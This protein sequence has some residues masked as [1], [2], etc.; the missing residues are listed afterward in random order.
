MA[1]QCSEKL[2]QAALRLDRAPKKTRIVMVVRVFLGALQGH[3]TDCGHELSYMAAPLDEA[4]VADLQRSHGKYIYH[5]T[6]VHVVE[7]IV[8]QGLHAGKPPGRAPRQPLCGRS[9]ADAV[10]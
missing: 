7:A 2:W 6:D 1:F 4:A 3:S 10:V 8:A 9:H 5:G